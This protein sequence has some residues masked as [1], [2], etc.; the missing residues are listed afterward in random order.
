MTLWK[1]HIDSKKPRDSSMIWRRQNINILIK[2]D[3]V[4][5]KD[6]EKALDEKEKYDFAEY[7]SATRN[8]KQ[9]E[10]DG[11]KTYEA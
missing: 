11:T 10:T 1:K 3:Y 9:D 8:K 5:K 4:P 6:E 7:D 2:S